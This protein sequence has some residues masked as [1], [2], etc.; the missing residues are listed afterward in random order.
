ML[1]ELTR[2]PTTV[3]EWLENV[4]SRSSDDADWAH[5]IIQLARNERGMY[6]TALM[7]QEL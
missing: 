1:T 6:A 2:K 5:R 4:R 3:K 7:E